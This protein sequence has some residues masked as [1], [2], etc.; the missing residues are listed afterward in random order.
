MVMCLLCA[1]MD[2]GIFLLCTCDKTNAAIRL[3]YA[4]TF[5]R[6]VDVICGKFDGLVPGLVYMLFDVPGYNKFKVDRRLNSSFPY[7]DCILMCNTHM[8]VSC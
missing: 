2:A 3:H 7:N 5:K 1:G 8:F 6:M 4:S